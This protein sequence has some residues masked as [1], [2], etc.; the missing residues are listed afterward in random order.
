[1][2]PS[3]VGIIGCGTLLLSGIL[4]LVVVVLDWNP[5]STI[6]PPSLKKKKGEKEESLNNKLAKVKSLGAILLQPPVFPAAAAAG[7]P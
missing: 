5:G 1:M 4:L 3:F 6:T 2:G 7:A